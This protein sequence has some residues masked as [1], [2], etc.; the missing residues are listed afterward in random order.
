M[1]ELHLSRNE[2]NAWRDAGAGDRARIVTHLAACASC[3]ELAAD[4]ERQRPAEIGP[5]RFSARD[6]VAS[7][8]RAGAS[9]VS[10]RS[11]QWMWA[12]AAAAVLIIALVPVWLSRVDDADDRLRGG[13]TLVPVRPVDT[14]VSVDELAFE[15]QGADRVRLNVV[16]LNRADAPLIDREVTGSRYEPTAEER[17]RFRS[18]QSLHWFVEARGGPGGTSP[19]ARFRVR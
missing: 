6:F 7:G 14:T 3:R 17:R 18:G 10:R 9:S 16:E 19:A 4:V 13:T 2:L 15:W 8:Y 5:S 11:R 1:S 12:T